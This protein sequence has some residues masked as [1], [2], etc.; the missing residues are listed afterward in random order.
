M[1]QSRISKFLIHNH[2]SV[3][4]LF[5]INHSVSCLRPI[6]FRKMFVSLSIKLIVYEFV[7]N[8]GV[9]SVYI[10]ITNMFSTHINIIL[11][12]QYFKNGYVYEMSLLFMPTP[13]DFVDYLDLGSM[14]KDELKTFL[15]N[16]FLLK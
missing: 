10:Y 5:K 13:I 9:R 1:F 15:M 11:S 4:K 6:C 7:D 12:Y 3:K 8:C 14:F 2:G 16:F